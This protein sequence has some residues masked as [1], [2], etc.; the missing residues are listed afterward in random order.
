MTDF[1]GVSASKEKVDEMTDWSLLERVL[2]LIFLIFLLLLIFLVI[3]THKNV[4]RVRQ[5]VQM[6]TYVNMLQIYTK[7]NWKTGI[8]ATVSVS[9]LM[10]LMICGIVINV[11]IW[12]DP[13]LDPDPES[14]QT[15]L[16]CLD[17]FS[18]EVLKI[19]SKPVY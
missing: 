15:S 11:M 6:G 18:S 19:I 5:S 10:L 16:T 4:P 9:V 1:L 8:F 2:Y 12:F 7:Y 17:P 13:L 3:K 14:G